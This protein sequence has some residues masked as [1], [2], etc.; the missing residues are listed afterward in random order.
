MCY[1]C[2][3]HKML[4]LFRWYSKI[5]V[6]AYTLI[7]HWVTACCVHV[8]NTDVATGGSLTGSIKKC[9]KH[10]TENMQERRKIYKYKKIFS[11]I[12]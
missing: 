3:Q 10:N 8:I 2:N 6:T 9:S 4:G 12:I 1:E 7:T 11:G 5:S